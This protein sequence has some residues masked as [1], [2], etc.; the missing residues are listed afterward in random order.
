MNGDGYGDVIVGGREFDGLNWSSAPPTCSSAAP[1]A[2]RTATPPRPRPGSRRTTPLTHFGSS[3]AGAGDV[4]GDGYDDVIVGETS[5][6]PCV[7]S[8]GRV[9]RVPRQRD[10]HRERR[11]G[12]GRLQPDRLHLLRS[13][14]AGAG[15]VNGDGYADVTSAHRLAPTE[16]SSSSAARRASRSGSRVRRAGAPASGHQTASCG[17]ASPGA[18]D[19]NGDGFDDVGVV[20]GL[21]RPRPARGASASSS[22]RSSAIRWASPRSP[23]RASSQ[24]PTA[25]SA[26]S[27][28]GAGDVNGD[29]FDDV[30]VGAAYYDDG[31]AA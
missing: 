3:V 17:N 23:T 12:H 29:G 10:G 2:S 7:R 21:R 14:V 19:V 15:D 11:P 5:T 31:A 18:G 20:G 4:N 28:A 16:R 26:S 22:A 25:T 13:G 30:I 1:S 8:E 6:T 27:V 9:A 24:A